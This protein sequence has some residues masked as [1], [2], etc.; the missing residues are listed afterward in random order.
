M[1]TQIIVII[2]FNIIFLHDFG[3][4]VF[5]FGGIHVVVKGGLLALIQTQ[6]ELLLGLLAGVGAARELGAARLR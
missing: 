3:D 6:S 4:L 1:R 2:I 5:K